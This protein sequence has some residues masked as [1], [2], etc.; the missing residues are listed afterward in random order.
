MKADTRKMADGIGIVGFGRM[1][2]ALL[3]GVLKSGL[4]SPSMAFAYDKDST[5]VREMG[6]AGISYC[7]ASEMG[8]I[9][10]TIIVAVKPKDMKTALHE[11][12]PGV[13]G[14]N[15]VVSVAAGVSMGF[16]RE[17]LGSEVPVARVMPNAGVLVGKGACAFCVSESVTRKQADFMR[18][19]LET[20]GCVVR[21][22]EAEMDAV[23]GLSGSGPAYVYR[24]IEALC[25]GGTRAGLPAETAKMLAIHTVA[26]AAET[27]AATTRSIEELVSDVATPGGTT[28]EGLRVLEQGDFGTIVAAAVESAAE[29]SRSIQ[30]GLMSD[31]AD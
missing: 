7:D 23:T 10:G 17:I 22:S 15:L 12:R 19:L 31:A 24:F 1:G 20:V 18:G 26:G 4:I 14:R 9:C 11:L 2:G 28:A 6:N 8:G 3:R 30:R 16:V 25:L 29:R 5:R 13:S 27:V 21:V